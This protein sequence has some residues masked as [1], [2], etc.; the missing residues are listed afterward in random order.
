STMPDVLSAMV[1]LHAGIDADDAPT[2]IRDVVTE[3][4]VSEPLTLSEAAATLTPEPE[5]VDDAWLTQSSLD[6]VVSAPT[7]FSSERAEPAVH[8]ALTWNP[9]PVAPASA[10]ATPSA[11]PA[12][13]LVAPAPE[14]SPYAPAVLPVRSS[15]VSELL[16]SFH[17]TAA[18]EERELRSAL[19]EMAGLSLTPMPLP[20]A[21]EG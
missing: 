1:A 3:L 5:L 9:G 11:P 19:K 4:R 18:A 20:V 2:R 15:D 13:V 6:G 7:V 10:V 21:S 12:L 17:V 14:P 8:E 16:D